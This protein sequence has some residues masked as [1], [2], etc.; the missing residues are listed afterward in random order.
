MT[1]YQPSQFENK[2]QDQWEKEEIYKTKKTGEKQYVLVMFPYPSGSGLHTGHARIYTASDVIARYSRMNG[3]SVLFP[4]GWDAFGLPAENAAIKLGKNPSDLTNEYIKNFKNQIKRL[5][6]SN[7][8]E[9]ELSTSD[10]KYYAITQ[11]LFIQFFKAGLLYKKDT[12][13][14]FCE[15]CKTGLA[16]EEVLADGT[17]ERCGNKVVKKN[18]PQWIFRITKYADRLLN[19]LEP[20]SS[21]DKSETSEGPSGLDWPKGILE[22]QKNWIGK[23][24]GMIIHH[25]INTLPEHTLDTFTAYPAWS[26]ADTFIAVAPE[27]PFVEKLLHGDIEPSSETDTHTLGEYIKKSLS[28]SEI[29]RMTNDTNKTGVFTGFYAIDPFRGAKMPIW[30]ADFVLMDFGTGAVRCS[31]HDSRDFEFAKKYSIPL[32]EV[33]ARTAGKP[34]N[35]HDNRGLL[36]DSGKFTGMEVGEIGRAFSDWVEKHGIGERRTSY[37]LRDW[38]F[39]RQRY[40]GEP[41]PMVFCKSCA[42]K[43]ISYKPDKIY[44]SSPKIDQNI[45]ENWR[46]IASEMVGWFPLD[47]KILPLELPYLE[48]YEPTGT[49]ESPLSQ[50]TDW[51]E[52]KCPQCG[53]E[54]RRE[55]DTMPNWAGSSWYFLA[56][57]FWNQSD[58]TFDLNGV[59]EKK[60]IDNWLPVDWYIGGADQAVLHLL[61]ARFWTKILYDLGYI[62][63]NEPFLK[64]HSVGMV[65]GE[66]N[67]KMSKSFGNVISPDTVIEEYGAD[68]LRIYEMFMAPF[69]Q[70]IVWSTS[71]LQ[72]SYRFVKRV[73]QLFN[74]S[75]KMTQ[76]KT[77]SDNNI[78]IELQ[79]VIIKISSDISDVKFNTSIAAM[80][81]FINVWEDG[82]VLDFDNA[83]KFLQVLAPF[84]PFL[85]DQLWRDVLGE[86]TSIHLS[87]WPKADEKY[88]SIGIIKLPVQVDGKMRDVIQVTN[89]TNE[90]E[91]VKLSRS[92]NKVKKFLTDNYEVKYVLGRIINFINKK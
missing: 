92:S 11:W 64:L 17:H 60:A 39:S 80:M 40:W 9:N 82:G 30:V 66:D 10:P 57:P 28:K 52:T 33:V 69:N 75:A 86:K 46:E 55:T 56:Y 90:D 43:K 29:D 63:F 18:L 1:P 37:H 20:P 87:E 42:D 67:R 31:A 81:Q 77:N 53:G 14:Y 50:V 48:K 62:T 36:L 58:K 70:E 6:L 71:A 5:G 2:V 49:G 45:T 13:V 4:M 38:I 47:E 88:L 76:D 72:G 59:K 41:I 68:A 44:L 7:D 15:H 23:K 54:A 85:T 78:V 8:W 3:K 74:T 73:W 83:K 12:E 61:Y 27:H 25:A 84:A 51:V 32:R 89:D 26:Y 19:D 35:A 34:V 24:E 21:R 79:N 22:M 91:V 65:I 16:Q